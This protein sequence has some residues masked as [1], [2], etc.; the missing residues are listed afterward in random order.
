MLFNEFLFPFCQ[1]LMSVAFLGSAA[2]RKGRGGPWSVAR[3]PR[4]AFC[5]CSAGLSFNLVASLF[6]TMTGRVAERSGKSRAYEVCSKKAHQRTEFRA[7]DQTGGLPDRAGPSPGGRPSPAVNPHSLSMTLAGRKR[8]GLEDENQM[9]ERLPAHKRVRG[10]HNREMCQR[11]GS[12]P[13][14]A[15]HP[16]PA[17]EWISK[18]R[19]EKVLRNLFC[20]AA[21]LGVHTEIA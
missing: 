6:L 13:I 7:H 8:K 20:L 9:A 16:G 17:P 21:A 10:E 4:E 11:R 14:P 15:A 2:L 19:G 5:F 3:P 18:K 12:V 1:R